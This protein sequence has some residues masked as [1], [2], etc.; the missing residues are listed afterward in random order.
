MFNQV[1]II[2][3]DLCGERYLEIEDPIKIIK[4][5]NLMINRKLLEF[6]EETKMKIEKLEVLKKR[7]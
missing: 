5:E 4:N 7:S 1:G 6:N 2:A 3:L